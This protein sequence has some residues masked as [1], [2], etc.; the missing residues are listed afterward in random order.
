EPFFA[1][2]SD[3]IWLD[4]HENALARMTG[5]WDESRMDILLLAQSKAG[6]VGYDKGEDHLFVKPDNTFGWNEQEAPYI[7]AGL[8]IVHPRIFSQS[9]EGKFSIKTLWLKALAQNRLACLP[10]HGRWF[11]TGTLADIMNAERLL[12]C[13]SRLA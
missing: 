11:Q 2:N 10:H 12:P 7:V 5:C 6:A 8:A 3:I 9:P 1:I 4:E 13:A